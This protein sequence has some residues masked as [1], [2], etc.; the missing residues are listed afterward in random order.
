MNCPQHIPQN[1]DAADVAEPMQGLQDRLAA[2]EA[3]NDRLRGELA[4]V[5]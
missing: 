2:T 4:A 3:E 5:R 1:F